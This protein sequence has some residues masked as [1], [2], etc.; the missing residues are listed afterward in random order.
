MV[1]TRV[2]QAV[3]LKSQV[4]VEELRVGQAE[5]PLIERAMELTDRF[6]I[7]QRSE[8][9]TSQAGACR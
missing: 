1:V 3:T 4:K 6:S 5:I 9:L 2:Q 7:Y 8:S